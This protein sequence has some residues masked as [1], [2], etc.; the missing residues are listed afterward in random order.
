MRRLLIIEDDNR[1]R[2][3]LVAALTDDYMVRSAPNGREGIAFLRENPVDVVLTDILMDEGDGFTVLAHVSAMRHKPRVIVLTV[4]DHAEKAA[5][6]IKLGANDYL[7]KPCTL[8]AVRSTI[9]QVLGVP[10]TAHA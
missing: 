2:A 6:A 8:A 10:A 3:T 5:K 4:I 9:Q 7:L 1:L